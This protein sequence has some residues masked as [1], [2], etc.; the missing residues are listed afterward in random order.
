LNSSKWTPGLN[1]ELNLNVDTWT[2]CVTH[3]MS[4]CS[5]GS[6]E[7][8]DAGLGTP[9][10]RKRATVHA[11]SAAVSQVDGVYWLLSG[12]QRPRRKAETRELVC[13]C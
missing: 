13:W 5:G 4:A 10:R 1:L 3:T 2:G 7:F 8:T 6:S 9:N 12:C 11:T